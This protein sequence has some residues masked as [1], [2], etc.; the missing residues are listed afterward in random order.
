MPQVL[1]QGRLGD[2]GGAPI[3]GA[4]GCPSI[5]C[6]ELLSRRESTHTTTLMH[7]SDARTT[8]LC[9]WRSPSAG[10]AAAAAAVAARDEDCDVVG[11]GEGG[12]RS[13]QPVGTQPLGWRSRKL[14]T[15]RRT[16]QFVKSALSPAASLV[17][18]S[19]SR[20]R[21]R[22]LPVAQNRSIDARS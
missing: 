2:G 13:G 6:C 14:A 18:V 12:R 1:P 20:R 11:L 3:S 17:F 4:K 21:E 5:G 16:C 19:G 22:A 7:S 15:S 8:K 9:S 10:S